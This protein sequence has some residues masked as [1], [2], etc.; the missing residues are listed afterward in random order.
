MRGR[1]SWAGDGWFMGPVACA[2]LEAE[3][4]GFCG[5]LEGSGDFAG[6]G[7]FVTKARKVTG[8]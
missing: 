7:F 8:S 6:S 5:S 3:R 4:N 1:R 2:F